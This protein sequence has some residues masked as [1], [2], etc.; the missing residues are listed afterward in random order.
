MP[1][2][3]SVWIAIPAKD[4]AHSIEELIERINALNL[5]LS[6]VVV[7]DCSQ[8]NTGER[9]GKFDNVV[10]HRNDTVMGYGGTTTKLYEIA[11]S[12]N[13][14]YVINIHGDLGHK[15]E[16]LVPILATLETTGAGIVVGS[17]LVFL[18]KNFREHGL[19][20]LFDSNLNGGMSAIRLAGHLSLTFIQNILF[21]Q[22]LNSYHEGMRGCN[23][24]ALAWILKQ[25]LPGWYDYDST[26]LVIAASSNVIIKEIP[27]PPYYDDRSNSA[28]PPFRYGLRVL[29][30][31]LKSFRYLRSI[32]KAKRK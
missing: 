3:K 31:S 21:D 8:D 9:A 16:D 17:R 13:A 28:A 7:D 2:N 10:V 32:G 6:I 25:N 24:E 23:K 20:V 29:F 18:K 11:A 14:D 12:K 4:C 1:V 15:P 19:K 26:L 27:T 22:R 5:A 30:N